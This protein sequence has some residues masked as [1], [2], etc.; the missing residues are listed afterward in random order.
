MASN[1]ET[2]PRQN[3]RAGNILKSMTSKGNCTLIR[4]VE[5]ARDQ[6]SYCGLSNKSPKGWYLGKRLILFP[7]NLFFSAPPRE[8]KLTVSKGTSH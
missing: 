8:T 4:E 7:S 1:N 3:I 6:F 5:R 2:F